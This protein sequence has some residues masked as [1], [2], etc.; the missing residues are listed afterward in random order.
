MYKLSVG[1]FEFDRG[2]SDELFDAIDV[3]R[4]NGILFQNRINA[5]LEFRLKS[6]DVPAG[7]H[8]NNGR[9]AVGSGGFF[10]TKSGIRRLNSGSDVRCCTGP[11]NLIVPPLKFEN[12]FTADGSGKRTRLF[13]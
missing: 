2:C 8:E 13:F 5:G 6:N 11:G 9:S 7:N 1:L 3:S 4:I 10:G 12:R